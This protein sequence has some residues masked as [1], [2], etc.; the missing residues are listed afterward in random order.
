M[1]MT[2]I[3]V[4]LERAASRANWE[5]REEFGKDFPPGST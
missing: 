4:A 2:H 5:S 1:S 3:A